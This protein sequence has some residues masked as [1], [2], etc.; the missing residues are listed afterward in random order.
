LRLISLLRAIFTFPFCSY[1][2]NAAAVSACFQQSSGV[3][4]D[5]FSPVKKGAMTT[6]DAVLR[7]A[8]GL[9]ACLKMQVDNAA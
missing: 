6:G 3:Q 4:V 1:T 5:S 8:K 2:A 9:P 7:I